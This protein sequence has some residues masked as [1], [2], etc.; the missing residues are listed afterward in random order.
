M[1]GRSASS[2][3]LSFG[4]GFGFARQV[5][6]E[7]DA[8]AHEAPNIDSSPS[9]APDIGLGSPY[10]LGKNGSGDEQDVVTERRKAPPQIAPFRLYEEVA[11]QTQ[12]SKRKPDV[13]KVKVPSI[14]AALPSVAEFDLAMSAL[15]SPDK[16]K[17]SLA[18]SINSASQL[19]QREHLEQ[20]PEQLREEQGG[21]NFGD[22]ESLVSSI[23][24]DLDSR[25]SDL[26]EEIASTC[27]NMRV[28][29][30]V[31]EVVRDIVANADLIEEAGRQLAQ[32]PDTQSTSMSTLTSIGKLEQARRL[33][34]T[35]SD[36]EFDAISVEVEVVPPR[37][38]SSH[39]VSIS[40]VKREWDYL[41]EDYQ[42]GICRDLLAC[43]NLADCSHSFCGAC[44]DAHFDS[45]AMKQSR[46]TQASCP[47]CR[48]EIRH[49][50]YER[51]LDRDIC[52][53]VGVWSGENDKTAHGSDYEYPYACDEIA[54]ADT[55]SLANEWRRRREAYQ[56]LQL[57]RKTSGAAVSLAVRRARLRQET[58]SSM[59]LY[60]RI[61]GDHDDDEEDLEE[62]MERLCEAASQLVIPLV[63]AVILIVAAMRNGRS[64]RGLP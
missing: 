7:S 63:C 41:V 45:E 30:G 6:S 15:L 32:H 1:A 2:I 21:E 14:H 27:G 5:G 60:E 9:A 47:I 33:E 17:D 50:T 59:P 10:P 37:F 11:D 3:A 39:S 42:C 48:Q 4:F 18:P 29:A 61:F 19:K 56:A 49:V 36:D 23:T 13:R 62:D 8:L 26:S 38:S 55:P 35:E 25:L 28:V 44:V 57:K 46:K 34:V 20:Q 24:E 51:V 31:V 53:K 40:A 54:D 12:E 16:L 52:R 43:P 22:S 64:R 58:I